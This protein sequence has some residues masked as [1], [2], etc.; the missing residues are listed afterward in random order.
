MLL[1]LVKA[2]AHLR[3]RVS[4][5]EYNLFVNR[6]KVYLRWPTFAGLNGEQCQHGV[7]YIVIMEFPRQPVALFD[8]WRFIWIRVF[9]IVTPTQ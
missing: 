5:S 1:Q 2:L 4:A 8:F 3:R 6:H 7:C 9:K